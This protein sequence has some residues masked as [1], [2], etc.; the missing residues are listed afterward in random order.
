[1]HVKEHKRKIVFLVKCHLDIV[2]LSCFAKQYPKEGWHTEWIK[3]NNE[4]IHFDFTSCMYV[5]TTKRY[6]CLELC[7]LFCANDDITLAGYSPNIIFERSET[8]GRG[9]SKCDF[10][11]INGN[12]RK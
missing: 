4:E 8:I 3:Y 7:P 12:Y 1:M 11:F 10:H 5:E 9:Q 6:N 2:Y